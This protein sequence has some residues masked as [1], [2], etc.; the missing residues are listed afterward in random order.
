MKYRVILSGKKNTVL[1]CDSFIEYGSQL[2]EQLT[3]N[4]RVILCRPVV[5]ELDVSFRGYDYE[6]KISDITKVWDYVY[7]IKQQ[8]DIGLEEGLLI[9]DILQRYIGFK[10]YECK[11]SNTI[12][13]TVLRDLIKFYGLE[14]YDLYPNGKN[15]L[16]FKD[17]VE[18][19][20]VL[21][22]S[23]YSLNEE[24]LRLFHVI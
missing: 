17:F 5:E 16:K 20:E 14:D 15:W 22:N 23:E 4:P 11:N 9:Q 7:Y 21:Y 10:Y 24:Q 6:E 2:E 8:I 13:I 1:Y 18:S 19:T 12:E 3:Y